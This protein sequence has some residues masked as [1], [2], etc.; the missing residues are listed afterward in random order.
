MKNDLNQKVDANYDYDAN[1]YS[2]AAFNK[3]GKGIDFEYNP[4]ER[5][6][7]F[8]YA[9]S[10]GS[11]FVPVVR[12][13]GYFVKVNYEYAADSQMKDNI[14][15]LYYNISLKVKLTNQ[16]DAITSCVL[17]NIKVKTPSRVGTLSIS[18]DPYANGS[19]VYTQTAPIPTI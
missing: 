8:N 10:K 18:N 19:D 17:K 12:D 1:F 3:D 11:T 9:L 15:D 5:T 2:N 13:M 16:T 4:V 7:S 6:F 14:A